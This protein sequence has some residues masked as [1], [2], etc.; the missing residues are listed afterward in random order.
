MTEPTSVSNPVS[1]SDL[2]LGADLPP[3]VLPIV[4]MRNLV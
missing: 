3:D 4:P 2:A 1:L